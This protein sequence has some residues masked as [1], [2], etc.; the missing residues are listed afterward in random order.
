M[1]YNVL[2]RPSL[3]NNY[4]SMSPEQRRDFDF[5]RSQPPPEETFRSVLLGALNELLDGDLEVVRNF[6]SGCLLSP[7]SNVRLSNCKKGATSTLNS[8]LH[9]GEEG[10]ESVLMTLHSIRQRALSKGLRCSTGSAD[11]L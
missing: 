11:L 9:L 5:F 1:A 10:I 6:L 4:D 3:K 8:S 2:S 7:I